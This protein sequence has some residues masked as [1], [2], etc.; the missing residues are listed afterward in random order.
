MAKVSIIIPNINGAEITLK[1]L[2]A[3]GDCTDSDLY[4]AIVVDNGSQGEEAE[5]IDLVRGRGGN[6]IRLGKNLFFGEA[7]NIG[8]EAARGDYLLFMN[9]DVTVSDGWLS[10]LLSTIESEALAG[11]VGPRMLYPDGRLQEAGGFILPN[12]ITVQLGKN[13]AP[14]PDAY[15]CSTQVVDYCS[16]ACLLVRR[17]DFLRLGGFDPYFE[18]AYFEDVDLALRL[19]CAGLFSY[20]CG[21]SVIYHEEGYSARQVWAPEEFS[22]F[23]N[24]NYDRFRRR[25]GAYLTSRMEEYREPQ[26]N[27][28]VPW[29]EESDTAP[30][31]TAVALYSARPLSLSEHSRAVL[32]AAAALQDRFDVTIAGD[33]ICSR[34][35]IYSLCRHLG[36]ALTAFKVRKLAELDR[37]ATVIPCDD[38]SRLADLMDLI[39][40][41]LPAREK[42]WI[43]K[44]I[45]SPPAPSQAP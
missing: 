7:N 36:V 34:L 27:W 35:R 26:G 37:S 21:R 15:V 44:T 6:L 8:A 43:S 3:I 2:D 17:R 32:T 1:C 12:G 9:N 13:G 18:P 30:E 41:G 14:L 39:D 40:N 23:W 28:D 45:A 29:R 5:R 4:E 24:R 16:A 19:R 42:E 22:V 20:F 33:A 38:G 10:T 31:R 25:W 11:A